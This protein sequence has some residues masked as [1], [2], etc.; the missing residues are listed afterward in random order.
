VR[1][2]LPARCA[3]SEEILLLFVVLGLFVLYFVKDK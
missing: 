1:D 3:V 2:L